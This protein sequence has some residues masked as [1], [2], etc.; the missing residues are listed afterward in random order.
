MITAL[1]I[2]AGITKRAQIPFSAWLPAAIAAPTPVSALVHSSTLVTAGVYIII[3]FRPALQQSGLWVLLFFI[4]TITMFIA[5]LGANYE[6]DLKKIIALSTLR[7]LG[8]I[9]I[10][11][12]LGIPVLAFFHLLTHAIFKALLFLCAGAV[13]HRSV[14]WQDIRKLGG[15]ITV[16]PLTSA[17]FNRA[18]MALCGLPFLA[19]FYSRDLI[20]EILMIG[21]VNIFMVV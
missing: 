10:I 18:N 15:V 19:G 3:R 2:L 20:L 8:V 7:Q 16:I 21:S 4:S 11:L 6:F 17:C 13:I 12:S 9:I 14:D 1:V 5:G